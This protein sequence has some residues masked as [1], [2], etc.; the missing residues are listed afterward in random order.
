VSV[1]PDEALLKAMSLRVPTRGGE[2]RERRLSTEEVELALLSGEHARTL[3]TY[4][5]EAEYAELRGLAA[6]ATH[7]K[8]SPGPRVLILPGIL[9][10]TLAEVKGS[11]DNT[12]WVDLFEI[13]LGRLLRL[14]L[15]ETSRR[16]RANGV[17][18]STYLKLKFKLQAEGF[19]ADFHPFDWR[20]S[21]PDLGR[22]LA[23]RLATDPADEICVVGHSMGGLVARLAMQQ[24]AGRK[25]KR[26][27]MLGTPNYGSFAPAMVYR[28]AYPFLRKLALLADWKNDATDLASKVFNT[29]PGL[30]QL[31]PHRGKFDT[32]D[33]FDLG[34]WPTSGARPLAPLLKD[35]LTVHRDLADA[36]IPE[37]LV[38]IAGVDRETTVGLRVDQAKNEFI[39]ERS[40]AGDGTVP[41]EFAVIPKVLTYYHAEEH[42]GLPKNPTIQK[43]VVDILRSGSTALLA[44]RWET[45]RGDARVEISETELRA[46]V[47]P[48]KRSRAEF[49][50]SE[51]RAIIAEFAAPATPGTATV[52]IVES[53]RPDDAPT[54]V[55]PWESLVVGRRRQRRIDVQVAHGSLTQV[56]SR[57]YLLGIFQN[58]EPGGAAL[59]ID[60]LMNG[61]LRE[62]RQRRMFA[63]GAGEVLIVPTG[64]SEVTAEYVV[65][66][67]LGHFDSFNL[68]VLETVAEN[69][70]RTLA[71][72][73][74]EEF[75]TVPIGAGTG[76][77]VVSALRALLRGFF[78]G[79]DDADPGHAFRAITFCEVDEAR[80][81]QLKWTLYRLW[82]TPLCDGVEVMLREI[83]L[84]P[85]PVA[86]RGAAPGVPPC[87]YLNVRARSAD[88]NGKQL[89]FE[90]SLLTTGAKAAVLSGAMKVQASALNSLLAEI[91]TDQF[92]PAYLAKFGSALSALVLDPA[93][94]AGLEGTI[95][96]H[97]VV[98][99][100]AEA[101]RI[102]WETLCV[103]GKFPSLLGGMSRRYIADNLSVAKWL[104]QRRED[105]WLDVL[106]VINPTLDLDGA[107]KEGKRVEELFNARQR[108]HL[109]VIKGSDATRARLR[110]EFSSGKY[111]ILH[112]AGHAYFDPHRPSGSGV[113]CSDGNLTG[114]ELVELGNLPSLVFFNA[115]ESAR[116]R[117]RVVDKGKH[118]SRNVRD[119][120]E[121][122]AGLAE[123]F[124]RAG[125][126]NYM[127]TYW[128][129]GD[130][131]ADQ[132]AQ[133]FYACVIEGDTLATAVSKGRKAVEKLRSV[134]W[135]DYIFYGSIDFAV[136]KNPAKAT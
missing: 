59:A 109:T 80:F 17:I 92:K 117:S 47:E 60:N 37:K 1:G 15:P 56:R 124:M 87:I 14:A 99:H 25:V 136:K 112:Y 83:S 28:S 58:V 98:V 39:F 65:F 3:E 48:Q 40:R 13:V 16:Y 7:R 79:L 105:E 31:L 129:V 69:V 45:A 126:A 134:D 116:V 128:P 108:V 100:D 102:P 106:L 33:L 49:S 46:R 82:S 125:V 2:G 90:S 74:I 10:S 78:R 132:F 86:R 70:A 81:E 111:D 123:A 43:A 21:L 41:L 114:A 57:A 89:V 35:A 63:A 27:I 93:V 77:D 91:E 76:I 53:A 73:D 5:G 104:E 54:E 133:V 130:A 113:V 29:H 67:G 68:Q 96:N 34:S 120:I 52:P 55:Q 4:F 20:R 9:G 42:G 71:R 12:L 6:Q 44:D 97:V 24:A 38:M 22:D 88:K 36:I 107:E 84:P 127:G 95:G 23:A 131:G 115:C 64:R 19:S 18:E 51:L 94:A 110:T 11:G 119:R 26:L 118:V 122:N 8:R 75:A 66:I 30:A 62:F 50:A 135:A 61:T 121:R 103:N 101:S 72:M 32:T 85:A